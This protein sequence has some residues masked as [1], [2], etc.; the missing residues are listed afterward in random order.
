LYPRYF[1]LGGSLFQDEIPVIV[2]NAI[3]VFMHLFVKKLPKVSPLFFTDS[4]FYF[5]INGGGAAGC[6][7]IGD[8]EPSFIRLA[9]T[10]QIQE[11]V[12]LNE[13]KR[14]HV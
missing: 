13:R 10:R 5:I 9:L 1:A 3:G 8:A 4:Q 12:T 2:Y 14:Q 6:L 11:G 7:I